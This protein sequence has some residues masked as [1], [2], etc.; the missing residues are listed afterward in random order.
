MKRLKL[1]T[2]KNDKSFGEGLRLFLNDNSKN[3]HWQVFVSEKG[4]RGYF[5]RTTNTANLAK[6][7]AIAKQE[8]QELRWKQKQNQRIHQVV[9]RNVA[10]MFIKEY[11]RKVNISARKKYYQEMKLGILNRFIGD[12]ELSKLNRQSTSEYYEMRRQDYTKR[13]QAKGN[14]NARLS[15]A[16]LHSD[17]ITFRK[18]I[19]WAVDNGYLDK[20]VLIAKY[21]RDQGYQRGWFDYDEWQRI[22]TYIK[23][24]IKDVSKH[25]A[26]V[27]LDEKQQEID[28]WK[29]E[30]LY[31]F[32]MFGIHLGARIDELRYLKMRDCTI[33][34]KTNDLLVRIEKGKTGSRESVGMI[35]CV[36][37]Y[38]RLVKRNNLRENDFLFAELY[39]RKHAWHRTRLFR[40]VMKQTGIK[41]KTQS[42]VRVDMKSLRHS[43]AVYRLL[44]DVD[45][46]SLAVQMGTSAK[47]IQSN[48]ARHLT[49]RMRSQEIT[50]MRKA[51]FEK[52]AD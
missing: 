46:F 33:R 45:V 51:D 6:A 52:L 26:D 29:W 14:E 21:R 8:Y 19:S 30:Q 25:H 48:Y 24:Q 15:G 23:Q 38:Q 34:K 37:A 42:N 41:S 40:Q 28:I 5:T 44:A 9:F 18:V 39:K 47:I 16:T 10:E 22:K 35:G 4:K 12:W 3:W 13:Q 20:E 36:R 32:C 43:Y 7:K 2:A 11:K 50:K 1:I 49:A 31:D 27:E 17:M